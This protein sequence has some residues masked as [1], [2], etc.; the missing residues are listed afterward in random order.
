MPPSGMG[1]EGTD[2][3]LGEPPQLQADVASFL[4]GSSKMTEEESKEISPGPPISQPAEWVQWKAKRCDVP[5]W[6]AELSTVPLEDIEKL[7]RQVRALF[8]LPKHMHELDPEEAPF[9]APLAPPCLHQWR[10]M[11]PIISAFACQDIWEIPREKTVTYARALQY[12]TEQR[13][14]PK[15]DQPH[16]LAESLAKLRREVGFYLSFMDEE[17][18]W[19]VY[20]SKEEEN[21]PSAPTTTATDTPGATATVE[22]L[23]TQRATPDYTGWNTILHPSQPVI[24]TGEVPWPT[25]VLWVKRRVLRTTRTILFSPPPKTPKASSPLRTPL[26]ARALALVR[27]PT[28][29]CSFAGVAACLRTPELV[30][31]DQN[32]P[33]NAMA[34]GMVSNPGMLSISSSRVVK[35][36]ETGLVYLDTMTTSTGRMVIGSMETREGSTI[37]DV[38]DQL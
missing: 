17:V 22:T 23:P 28:P 33:V 9:H 37:E 4:Q 19:G 38:T 13:N 18:F 21:K 35:D 2:S 10:F 20:L 8:K 25:T 7:A 29:P 31:V 30:E 5:D 6:W 27:P 24:A 15:K 32:T 14:L 1:S 34:M 3:D 16:P 26:P 11:P 12:L 36:N